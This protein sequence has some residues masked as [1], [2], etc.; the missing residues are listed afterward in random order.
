[1]TLFG[2][3]SLPAT[4]VAIF[5]H[6]SESIMFFTR[7]AFNPCQGS[8]PMFLEAAWA[9]LLLLTLFKQGTDE[10]SCLRYLFDLTTFWTLLHLFAKLKVLLVSL[11]NS[12]L[13]ESMASRVVLQLPPRLSAR[14]VVNLLS[15]YPICF[16]WPFCSLST[17]PANEKSDLL[18]AQASCSFAPSTPDYLTLSDPARSTRLSLE[19]VTDPSLPSTTLTVKVTIK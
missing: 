17:T 16:V 7:S 18:M 12:W 3:S 2:Q 6:Y 19:L 13:G 1:M 10:G 8:E 5:P 14:S 4:K 15:R 9:R 11:Q